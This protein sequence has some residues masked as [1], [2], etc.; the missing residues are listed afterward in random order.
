MVTHDV[1]LKNYAN[2]VIR[3]VDGKINLI[4]IIPVL[5]RQENI[6]HLA[7]VVEGYKK[8]LDKTN[9]IEEGANYNSNQ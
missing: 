6:N 8:I 7:S 3:M 4:E 9:N 2:R 5:K 1:A